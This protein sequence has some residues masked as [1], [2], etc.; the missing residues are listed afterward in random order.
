MHVRFLRRLKHILT[1][2]D[3]R[4]AR[5]IQ[6]IENIRDE[7]DRLKRESTSRAKRDSLQFDLTACIDSALSR[8]GADLPS[9][10]DH[11]TVLESRHEME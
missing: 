1:R 6:R 4:A 7:R 2:V 9:R 5:I 10:P 8:R 11:Q 3:G